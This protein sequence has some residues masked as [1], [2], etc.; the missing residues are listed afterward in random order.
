MTQPL[1]S[2]LDF[3]L[4]R[5]DKTPADRQRE[6]VFGLLVEIAGY[7]KA[8]VRTRDQVA[9]IVREAEGKR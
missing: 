8:L 2:D 6:I 7:R 9:K 1:P 3:V 5:W 4:E